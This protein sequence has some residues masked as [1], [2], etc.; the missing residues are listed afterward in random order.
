MRIKDGFALR[1][2]A[3]HHIVIGEGVAQV[4]F[5]KMVSMNDSAAYLWNSV[6][7]KDF[8][9]EDLANLLTDKYDVT[10]EKA[11]SAASEVAARWIEAGVVAR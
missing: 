10:Y 6:E 8:T 7:G 3:G 2:I 4:D 1:S 11:F 9:V 5:K